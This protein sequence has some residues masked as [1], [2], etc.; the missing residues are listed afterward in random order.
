MELSLVSITLWPRCASDLFSLILQINNRNNQVKVEIIRLRLPSCWGGWMLQFV[1]CV[2][3]YC[4]TGAAD[5]N[6]TSRKR[7]H[8]SR[9]TPV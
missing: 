6:H 8:T 3:S 5:R 9:K 2:Q 1:W 4:I 7:N